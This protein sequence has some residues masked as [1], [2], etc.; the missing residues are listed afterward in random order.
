MPNTTNAPESVTEYTEKLREWQRGVCE[1]MGWNADEVYEI[2][3]TLDGPWLKIEWTAFTQQPPP[4][5]GY[6]LPL[7]G[8]GDEDGT[9]F[10]GG[11]VLR[12]DEPDT[13]RAAVGEKPRL[14][15]RNDELILKGLACERNHA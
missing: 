3:D 8:W 1:W 4:R 10:R 15:S 6:P 12:G 13:L 11:A 2:T 5:V 7:S 14:L 9:R